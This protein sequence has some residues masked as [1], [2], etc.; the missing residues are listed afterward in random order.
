MYTDTKASHMPPTACLSYS[1]LQLLSY[2][3]ELMIIYKLLS[4][5]LQQ[6][7]PAV[8]ISFSTAEDQPGRCINHILCFP[9]P[10]HNNN[11]TPKD[12]EELHPCK[13]F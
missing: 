11:S 1:Q 9:S 2:W 6:R 12:L 13:I 7:Q 8:A 5:R 10:G 4:E 3:K